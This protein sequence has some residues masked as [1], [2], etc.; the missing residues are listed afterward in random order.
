MTWR[1]LSAD[2]LHDLRNVLLIDVRSPCEYAA[3][4]IPGAINVPLLEDD[5]R[6]HV[7][8]VYAHEGEIVARRL[9]LRIISPKIPAIVEMIL[10][11]RKQGQTIVVHCWRGGLRSESVASF[12]AIVGMDCWRLT[13]GYKA[14][15]SLVLKQFKEDEYKFQPVVLYGLTGAGKTDVLHA[16]STQG[17]HTLDLE[18]LANHRG[19]VFGSL[20]LAPQPTQKNF[21][22][23]MWLRLRQIGEETFYTEAEGRKIGKIS[24]PDFLLRRLRSGASILVESSLETRVQR[25]AA[26]YSGSFAQKGRIMQEVLESL[27]LLRTRLGTRRIEQIKEWF[28]AGDLANAVQMLLTDYYDPQ[29][30]K[31]ISDNAPYCLVVNA[32]DPTEA[33]ENIIHW[34]KARTNSGIV[35]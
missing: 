16:L 14:W 7:G 6:A 19:S 31:E 23:E 11:L 20:G 25:I 29:Y 18:S 2:R 8:T 12:L 15:R 4:Y 34:S 9:A 35:R 10:A 1:E 28:S 22:G 21:E 5:E 33:A 17:M 27:E 26:E 30:Q 32:D 13:G 24:L 3:E